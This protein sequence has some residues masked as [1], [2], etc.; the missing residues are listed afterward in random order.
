MKDLGIINKTIPTWLL[1]DAD[2]ESVGLSANR[3]HILRPDIMLVEASHDEQIA[4]A[5]AAQ[6]QPLS[7]ELDYH[8][9]N[10]LRQRAPNGTHAS[11]PASRTLP[12]RRIIWLLEG[13]YT[14]DTRYEEKYRE[15][16]DQ[17]R[18]LIEA[19][20]LKGFEVRQRIVALGVSGTIYKTTQSSLKDVGIETEP[21]KKL[22]KTLHQHAIESLHSIV[23]QRRKLDTTLIKHHTRRPP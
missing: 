3:R 19:L 16:Q 18:T 15:K 2:I 13:G 23:V 10:A 21:M 7:T 22:L 4:Y 12:R 20:E 6:I 5:T 1:T 8:V 11:Q 9:P 17:H 14:S